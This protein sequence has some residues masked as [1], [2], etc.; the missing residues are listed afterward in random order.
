MSGAIS[1]SF[2]LPIGAWTNIKSELTKVQPIDA[3]E[4]ILVTLVVAG[5][6][7]FQ[8]RVKNADGVTT[9][10]ISEFDEDLLE[11]SFSLTQEDL[12]SSSIEILPKSTL[13]TGGINTVPLR[14]EIQS[15]DGGLSEPVIT[16]VMNLSDQPLAPDASVSDAQTLE[17]VAINLP[18]S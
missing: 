4:S 17:D 8:V 6:G 11:S 10:I 16:V 5:E 1:P 15:V 2:D 7:N 3:T 14:L 13:I 12:N 9:Q 18:C